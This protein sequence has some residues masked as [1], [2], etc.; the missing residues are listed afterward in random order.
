[1]VCSAIVAN[2]ETTAAQEFCASTAESCT[3][4]VNHKYE[5]E[6]GPNKMV[7]EDASCNP[8]AI[9]SVADTLLADTETASTSAGESDTETT[10]APVEFSVDATFIIFDWD[11]TIL[12]TSWLSQNQLFINDPAPLPDYAK[13]ELDRVAEAA[14]SMLLA[15]NKAGKVVVITNADE[16]WVELSCQKFM[17]SLTGLMQQFPVISARTTFERQGV[18]CPFE[19]KVRAFAQEVDKFF[20]TV[21]GDMKRN[22]I[23]LGDSNH[24]REAVLKVSKS[25]LEDHVTKSV[26]FMVRPDSEQLRK[27]HDLISSCFNQVVLHETDLDMCVQ[28]E[29]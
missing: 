20:S 12:P 21:S 16:G 7:N 14:R 3:D 13:E 28:W 17:P 10:A 25:M 24:E 15:A 26:K 1:M 22:I 29:Q 19:W 4:M 6:A 18:S 27:Q 9:D 11:D 8:M 2:V 5:N 23:S